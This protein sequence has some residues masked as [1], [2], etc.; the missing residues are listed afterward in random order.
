MVGT[1]R[2]A[3]PTAQGKMDPATKSREDKFLTGNTKL[4]NDETTH[5]STR[6]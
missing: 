2:F 4:I 3:H 6:P 5:W 1:L